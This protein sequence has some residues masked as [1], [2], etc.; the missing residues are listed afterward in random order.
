[1][2][3]LKKLGPRPLNLGELV[4]LLDASDFEYL[5]EED[6]VLPRQL[7]D[8]RIEVDGIMEVIEARCGDEEGDDRLTRLLMQR[9]DEPAPVQ[10]L[11]DLTMRALVDRLELAWQL[12]E[13][14][15][16]QYGLRLGLV[17]GAV[18]QSTL[19]DAEEATRPLH[20]TTVLRAMLDVAE[21]L[22]GEEAMEEAS[23]Q[24][25]R[26]KWAASGKT[27]AEFAMPSIFGPEADEGDEAASA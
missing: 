8:R 12:R 6:R 10:P 5:R 1:M 19:D 9:P 23:R 21:A 20:L 7:L 24:E 11:E 18:A 15:A 17:L 22:D 13:E 3:T 16:L 25:R 4:E 27:W 14:E 2:A 26:R